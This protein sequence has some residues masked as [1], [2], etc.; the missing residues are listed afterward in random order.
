MKNKIKLKLCN[1]KDVVFLY[2]LYN[3]LVKNKYFK[4]K[5]TIKYKDHKN[6]FK[7][8]LNTDSS[9]IYIGYYNSNKFG[10]VRFNRIKHKI[11]KVSIGC[12][13]EY[14]NKGYGTSLLKFALKKFISKEKPNKIISLIKKNNISSQ[15]CF[16]KNDFK[17]SKYKKNNYYSY[18]YT[19]I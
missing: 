18:K 1:S 13:L 8:I 9:K 2:K 11:Y 6:W 4:T 19:N 5:N 17:K 15:K 7:E 16:I 12:K 10:Y 3:F 14:Q